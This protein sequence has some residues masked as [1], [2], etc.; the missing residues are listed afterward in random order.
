MKILKQVCC[1]VQPDLLFTVVEFR[2]N[3]DSLFSLDNVQCTLGN[4]VLI[5]VYPVA[6]KCTHKESIRLNK[7]KN[8]TTYPNDEPILHLECKHE[9]IRAQATL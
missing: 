4:I 7:E 2:H 3:A 6:I 5:K 8:I 1:L 9:G